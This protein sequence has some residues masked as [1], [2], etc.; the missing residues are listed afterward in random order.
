MGNR[1][2]I[3]LSCVPPSFL[4]LSNSH[5]L[6][7]SS[8]FHCRGITDY[9]CL[10]LNQRSSQVTFAKLLYLSW[11]LLAHHLNESVGLG[12]L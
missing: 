3:Q 8:S 12:N 1:I 2:V 4:P 7:L 10:L 9:I 11:L 5:F 6:S